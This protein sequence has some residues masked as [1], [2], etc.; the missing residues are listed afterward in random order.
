[1]KA[2]LNHFVCVRVCVYTHSITWLS[3]WPRWPLCALSE[4]GNLTA[5][6]RNTQPVDAHNCHDLLP[7]LLAL[8]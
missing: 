7:F 4:T 5:T 2:G 1:M 3:S 6:Y 8:L